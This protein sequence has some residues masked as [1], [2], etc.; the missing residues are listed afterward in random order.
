MR[1]KN[2]ISIVVVLLV[3]IVSFNMKAQADSNISMENES[4]YDV[5]IDRFFDSNPHNNTQVNK[6]QDLN[7]AGGD[8]EGITTKIQHFED[9]N[10]TYLSVGTLAEAEDFRGKRVV[11]YNKLQDNFGTKKDYDE[12]YEALHKINIKVMA[13]F[14]IN[15]VSENN[16]LIPTDR[17]DFV[18]SGKEKGTVNWVLSTKEVENNLISAAKA[19]VKEYKLEGLRLTSIDGVAESFLNRMIKQLK[20]ENSNLVIISDGPSKANFDL[21]YDEQQMIAFQQTLKNTD[22]YSSALTSNLA[23]RNPKVPSTLMIDNLNST[24]FTYFAAEENKFPPTRVKIALGA[25][26]LLPGTPIVT[27][28]TEI[29]INGKQPPETLQNMDFRTKDD[30]IKYIGQLQSLRKGSKAL[31]TGEY[32]ELK[33]DNGFVV[34]ERFNDDEKWIIV[35][36]NTNKTKSIDLSEDFIGKNK[37]IFGMFEK[38]IIREN[39]ASNYRLVL[40]REMVEVYQVKDKKGINIAYLVALGLVYIIFVTFLVLVLKRGKKK[41]M[42]EQKKNEEIS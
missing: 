38:D 2:I 36:N 41:K 30:I 31:R 1:L 20:E 25:S 22:L 34:F 6:D 21:N 33:N 24:R 17:T 15:G 10:F 11:D 42:S 8:F 4:I 7:F 9:L 19:Y 14:P 39:D 12:M 40:D 29:S 27:Y 35:I 3:A 28:G 32:K 5:L 16:T 18:T 26:M 13:D 37:E 23:K